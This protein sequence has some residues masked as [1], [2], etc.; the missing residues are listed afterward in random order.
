MTELEIEA[1]Y[2]ESRFYTNFLIDSL[3][4]LTNDNVGFV[5]KPVRGGFFSRAHQ[6]RFVSMS[7]PRSL[8]RTTLHYEARQDAREDKTRRHPS[9]QNTQVVVPAAFR[10]LLWQRRS[11]FV[12]T[13]ASFLDA[14]SMVF[15]S[16]KFRN[17][18]LKD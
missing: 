14:T 12:G 2:S 10:G 13:I 7:P 1:D 5:R 9:Y 6:L 18:V 4:N 11:G 15:S 8:P 17:P 16:G 3:V